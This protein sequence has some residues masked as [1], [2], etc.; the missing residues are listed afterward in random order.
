MIE[1]EKDVVFRI[2]KISRLHWGLFIS[3]IFTTLLAGAIMEGALV[4]SNCLLYSS[5]AAED[6]LPVGW[7]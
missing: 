1:H 6:P 3:T 2:P 7:G 4:F 5:E